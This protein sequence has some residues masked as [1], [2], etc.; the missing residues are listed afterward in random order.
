MTSRKVAAVI[1]LVVLTISVPAQVVPNPF[2]AMDTGTRDPKH[3]TPEEQVA[4]IKSLGFDG[5]G[6]SYRGTN[7][8]QH[9]FA[10]LDRAGSKM[11]ALYVSLQLDAVEP[12]LVTLKEVIAALKGRDTMVWL[13]ITDKNHPPSASDNDDQAVKVLREMAGQA[14][15]AGLR[16]ALYPHAGCYVQRVE[17]AARLAEKTGR[18]NL[19]VTFNLCHWLKVDGQN[20]DAS[21]KAAQPYLFVVTVNGAD[22]DGKDWNT[23]IQPLDRG[24]YDVAQL[25]RRL[26]KMGYTGPVGLQHFGVNGDAKE[27]LQR[28]MTGWRKLCASVEK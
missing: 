22:R 5:V 6:P 9:W 14:Q 17:D 1:V 2:F 24:S 4:M 20:L 10:A 26:V 23:L 25:L 28:S 18:Q 13:V 19:G 21:L 3:Q 8:L 27:N 7:D 11:F 15:A 16:V 12:S